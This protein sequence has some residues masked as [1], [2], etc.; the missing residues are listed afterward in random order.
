MLQEFDHRS[1]SDHA[2][3]QQKTGADADHN[4]PDGRPKLFRDRSFWG[5]ITTQFLGAFNDNLY[6][7]LMLLLAIP[8]ASAAAQV[9]SDTPVTDVQGWAGLVFALPFVLFSGFAGYL[10]DRYSKTP[11]IVLCKYAEILVMALGLIAF[12]YYDLFGQTGT[13]LVLFLMAT[14]SA[15]FGPGKYGVLPELFREY[16]LARANA[17]MLMSTFLAI[18]LGIVSAG[19][20]KEFLGGES[21]Q[22]LWSGLLMCIAIAVIGTITAKMIRYVPAAHPQLPLSM[23]CLGISRDMSQLFRSDRPLLAAIFVSSIFWLVS[24]MAVP[25]VNRLGMEQLAVGEARTSILT[26]CVGLGIMLGSPI[27]SMICRSRWGNSAVNIGLG[28]IA[29]A[30]LLLGI[31]QDQHHWLGYWGSFVCLIG[32]GVFAS[33]FS[34][35]VMVF[36]QS[37]PPRELKG[38][39]IATM[40]QANF[41][42]ILL[43][44]PLYQL[45]EWLSGQ[46]GWPISSVFWMMAALVLPFAVVYRLETR[47]GQ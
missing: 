30:L 32:V 21:A 2:S 29:A 5:I 42:G 18:I 36:L 14:Q 28:G 31:W 16:D 44:G 1:T 46:F 39:L 17:L 20:V 7:Q 13:W 38:R 22:Q 9:S 40:N 4:A 43:A 37:R 45:F 19:V 15:F 8:A 26:A 34:I 35:P 27:S 23:D 11:I 47:T 33:I 41:M 25:T 3:G 12:W 24:G 10:S 6:K